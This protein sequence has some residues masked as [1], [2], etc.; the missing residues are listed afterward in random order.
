MEK[1][2]LIEMDPA[3][4]F[5]EPHYESYPPILIRLDAIDEPLLTKLLEDAWRLRAPPRLLG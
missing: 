1:G 4:F 2:V 5:T 3:V